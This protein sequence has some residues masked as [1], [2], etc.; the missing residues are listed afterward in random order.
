[1]I[2]GETLGEMITRIEAACDDCPNCLG[3]GTEPT[4][5]DPR[6]PAFGV[7]CQECDGRQKL[8]DDKRRE[9]GA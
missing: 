2:A 7:Q 9:L 4:P 5:H 8:I 6:D 3:T 1:M